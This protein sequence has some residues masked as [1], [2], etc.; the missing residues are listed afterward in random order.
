MP[1]IIRNRPIRY[2]TRAGKIKNNIPKIIATIPST[3]R[4]TVIPIL[5]KLLSTVSAK[6]NSSI[7]RRWMGL[8]ILTFTVQQ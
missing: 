7:R 8:A 4:E 1:S 2:E 5:L 6:D 3:G